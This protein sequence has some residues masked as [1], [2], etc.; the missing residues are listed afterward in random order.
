MT[1]NVRDYEIA[2]GSLH[3]R[4]VKRKDRGVCGNIVPRLFFSS[5]P[6]LQFC[7]KLAMRKCPD[8][9]TDQVRGGRRTSLHEEHLVRS[10]T[11]S[12]ALPKRSSHTWLGPL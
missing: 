12:A 3:E 1:E 10:I 8:G 5:P 7:V 2:D 11:D 4:N 6:S 9:Q